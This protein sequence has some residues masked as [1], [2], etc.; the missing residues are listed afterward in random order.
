M[1]FFPPIAPFL[2]VYQIVYANIFQ[3]MVYLWIVQF[4]SPKRCGIG[5][6]SHVLVIYLFTY[7]AWASLQAAALTSAMILGRRRTSK[8]DPSK[9]RPEAKET[10][11]FSTP[12]LQRKPMWTDW[13]F[14]VSSD[15]L[16]FEGSRTVP[17]SKKDCKPHP[18]K[19]KLNVSCF[20]QANKGVI[21]LPA[22]QQAG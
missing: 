19:R 1:D 10:Q 17:E 16:D 13:W 4:H 9:P 5:Y 15:I 20:H 14:L 3:L 18:R 22:S 7:L 2:S 21:S 8:E 6:P 11:S 12:F